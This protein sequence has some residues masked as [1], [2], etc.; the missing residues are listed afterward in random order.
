MLEGEIAPARPEFGE[1]VDP[2][3]EIVDMAG[4]RVLPEAAR[5][6]LPAPVG[7]GHAPPLP[8]PV[9]QRLEIFFVI[10]AAAREE[11]AI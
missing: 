6:C 10:V 4:H 9:V 8:V 11:S 1:I 7:R 3:A 2:V 5:S